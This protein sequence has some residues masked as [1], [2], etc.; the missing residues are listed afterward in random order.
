M[1]AIAYSTGV[2]SQTP[3]LA[4][5]ISPRMLLTPQSEFK[6]GILALYE[7]MPENSGTTRQFVGIDPLPNL[8]QINTYETIGV[9]PISP[10]YNTVSVTPTMY[11]QAVIISVAARISSQ[12]PWLAAIVNQM[13]IAGY[14]T[15]DIIT[16]NALLQA[17]TVYN[18]SNGS[19]GCFPTEMTG[20]DAAQITAILHNNMA[21][22]SL[23]EISAS[24]W[25]NTSGFRG[26]YVMLTS[27]L[28]ET[29]FTTNT[30][31]FST[32]QQA[33]SDEALRYGQ[34][35]TY[36]TGGLGV[37]TSKNYPVTGEVVSNSSGSGQFQLMS[38]CVLS[39][40][41]Y[42]RVI[43][44]SHDKKI[45]EV[46]SPFLGINN[47]QEGVSILYWGAAGILQ[48]NWCMKVE[49]TCT[50]LSTTAA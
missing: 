17:T 5:S 18:A 6:S 16:Y 19:N 46:G 2:G 31:E 9:S 21:P 30:D 48:R 43:F 7:P 40:A 27:V 10:T 14:R 36:K 29:T 45:A 26:G 12:I 37:F 44:P 8:T 3:P 22:Q 50:P 38:G 1:S 11:N 33:P 13:I 35:G 25:Y 4:P 39:L 47:L 49:F 34:L 41:S 20:T 24:D 32:V 28:A 23:S 15:E 42:A